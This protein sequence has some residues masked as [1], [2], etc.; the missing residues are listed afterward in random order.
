MALV[1]VGLVFEGAGAGGLELDFPVAASDRKTGF[2]EAVVRPVLR[3][4]NHL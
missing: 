2:G 3:R 4:I 1:L